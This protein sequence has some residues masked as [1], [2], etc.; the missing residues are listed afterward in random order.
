MGFWGAGAGV[1]SDKEVG[2]GNTSVAVKGLLLTHFESWQSCRCDGSG[3]RCIYM[4]A[5]WRIKFE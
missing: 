5:Q 4:V 1:E 2:G 3:C